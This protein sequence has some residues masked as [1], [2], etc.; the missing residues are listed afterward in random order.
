MPE[1]AYIVKVT[2]V[3]GKRDEAMATLGRLV[4][5]ADS[6]PGTLQYTLYADTTDPAGIW[7]TELY[8]D[9][10]AQ[11]AHMSSPTMAEVGRS[12][13]GLLD[14]P[15]DLRRVEIVRRKGDGAAG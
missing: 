2:V 9:E 15:P 8:V 4:D 11:E 1:V 6:E 12:L 10:A 7:I 13:G 14:G 3:E 5:A